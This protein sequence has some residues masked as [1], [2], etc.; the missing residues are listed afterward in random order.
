MAHGEIINNEPGAYK[1]NIEETEIDSNLYFHPTDPTWMNEHFKRMRAI[2]KEKASLFADPMFIDPAGGDFG[3]KE[4]SPAITLGIEPLD[5]S[6]MG[7][8]SK[9]K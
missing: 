9:S 3:F 7:L 1:P 5:V 6:K 2:G 4:G 8:K